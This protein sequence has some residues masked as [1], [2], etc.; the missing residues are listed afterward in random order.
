MLYWLF[1]LMGFHY[2]DT[3]NGLSTSI[4]FGIQPSVLRLQKKQNKKKT[5][6]IPGRKLL[7]C[8]Y[9]WKALANAPSPTFKA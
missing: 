5:K 9:G 2:T 1:I 6:L 7:T 3:S 8:C 4:K